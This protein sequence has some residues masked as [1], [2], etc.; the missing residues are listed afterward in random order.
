MDLRDSAKFKLVFFRSCVMTVYFYALAWCQFYLPLYVVHSLS[1]GA[2]LCTFIFSYFLLGTPIT[3]PQTRAILIGLIGIIFAGM[4]IPIYS[5]LNPDYEYHTE[6]ENYH[7]T[8]PIMQIVALLVLCVICVLWALS[9]VLNQFLSDKASFLELILHQTIIGI[10]LTS[11]GYFFLEK[12]VAAETYYPSWLYLGLPVTVANIMFN[13][14]IIITENVGVTTF[15]VT[16]GAVYGYF[17]SYLKYKEDLN[18]ICVAGSVLIVVCFYGLIQSVGRK[19]T[20]LSDVIRSDEG[21]SK[22]N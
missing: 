21:E 11:V 15:S 2:S 1:S 6:F 7:S 20:P 3:P 5:S 14:A 4:G 13:W 8:T 19:D 17:Y 16:A 12:P 18:Y 9:V 22:H 10:F